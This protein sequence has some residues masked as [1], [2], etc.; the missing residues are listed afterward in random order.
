[1]KT[2]D[3]GAVAIATASRFNALRL[4][5][6]VALICGLTVGGFHP[7][8]AAAGT[9]KATAKAATSGTILDAG[10]PD[11]IP[12]RYIVVLQPSA[13]SGTATVTS[14][15]QSLTSTYG[16]TVSLVEDGF[17]AFTLNGTDAIASAMAGDSQVSYVDQ[18]QTEE[19]AAAPAPPPVQDNPDWGLARINQRMPDLGS[20]PQFAAA[21]SAGA[22]IYVVDTGVQISAPDFGGRAS[23]AYDAMTKKDGAGP[24]CSIKIGH[25]TPV[26]ALAAGSVYG[27]AKQALIKS[28]KVMDCD[29]NGKPVDADA[30]VTNDGLDWILE[31]ATAPAVVNL[32]L[33]KDKNVARAD[34][35]NRLVYKGFIVVMAAGNKATDA[36]NATPGSKT[37]DGVPMNA[38]VVGATSLNKTTTP[39]V[40]KLHALSNFGNCVT[41]FAPGGNVISAAA[42][43]TT[44]APQAICQGTSFAAGY[45]SGAA[46]IL[47]AANPKL[48]QNQVK[49]ALVADATSPATNGVSTLIAGAAA[50]NS[51]DLL[52]HVAPPAPQ[53]TVTVNGPAVSQ[54][55][56]SGPGAVDF[57]FS[58][59]AGQSVYVN[60]TGG[61]FNANIALYDKMGSQLAGGSH[62]SGSSG[63]QES[64]INPVVLPL[65]GTYSIHVVPAAGASGT[66]AL[67]VLTAAAVTATVNGPAVTA[68]IPSS[69]PGQRIL[70]TF[71]G[72]AGA[73]VY[74]NGTTGKYRS[75]VTLY[76]PSGAQIASGNGS[77]SGSPSSWI[78]STPLSKTGTYTL[79]I[80]PDPGATGAVTFQVF[81]SDVTLT[82]TVDGAAVTG[83]IP[84]SLPGQH[85]TAKFTG[86]AG[87]SITIN[88]TTPSFH[89]S[90]TLFDPTG[91]QIASTNY[92]G[93][94]SGSPWSWFSS[95]PLSK[96]GTYTLSI[97]PDPGATGAVTLHVIGSDLTLT[98]TVDG[99]AVSG[100]IPASLP[101]QHVT[102]R[103]AGTAGQSVDINGA[104]N[105]YLSAL[106]LYDPTGAQIGS[107]NYSGSSSGS[108]SSWFSSV[109]L[110]TTGTYTLSLVPDAGA[111]GPVKVQVLGSAI[112]LTPTVDGAAVSGT[113]PAA[114][115]GKRI[116][117]TFSATAGQAIYINGSTTGFTPWMKLY[118]P[119]GVQIASGNGVTSFPGTPQTWIRPTNAPTTGTYTLVINPDAT[120]TGDFSLQ[121]FGSYVTGG[122][123]VNGAP[124]ALL[125]PPS[126]PGKIMAITFSGTAGSVVG[127]EGITGTVGGVLAMDDPDGAQIASGVAIPLNQCPEDEAPGTCPQV[128]IVPVTLPLTGT[129]TVY[130]TT[131]P[132]LWGPLSVELTGAPGV[133]PPVNLISAPATV[134][135]APATVSIPSAS[136]ANRVAVT[137]SATAGQAITVNS[138]RG[139]MDCS[140]Q[141]FSLVGPSGQIV[142]PQ[143]GV[144][145]CS[146]P[147]FLFLT[148]LPADGTYT[149]Y[150]FPSSSQTG[151]FTLQV[152]SSYVTASAT[153]DGPS[154]PI[155]IPSTSPGRHAALTFAGTAGQAVYVNFARETS[156]CDSQT[157]SLVGPSGQIIVPQTGISPCS[158]LV[159]L[160]PTVLPAT[161]T[162]TLYEF[163]SSTQSGT[164]GLQV[165]SKYLTATA[166]VDGPTTTVTIPSS[167]PGQRAAITF[168]GTAGQAIYVNSPKGTVD[169]SLMWFSLVGPS[170]QVV[171][172]QTGTRLCGN[173]TVASPTALP[174]TGTYTLYVTPDGDG[175]FGLQVLSQSV[176]ALATV[177][178]P[179]IPITVPSSSPGEHV[180]VTFSAGAG[181]VVYVNSASGTIDCSYMAFSLIG[182]SGQL[183]VPQAGTR[184]CSAETVISPIALPATGTY[185]LYLFPVA[186]QTGTFG[187]QVLTKY[188]AAAA[189]V[190]G[191]AVPITI[192]GNAP[193]QR[194]AETFSATAGQA[195]S[196]SEVS[197]TISCSQGA[198]WISL[199]GPS[200]QVVV[201][202]AG[203]SDLCG[204]GVILGKTGLP[205]TGTYTL[206][207]SPATDQS[208]TFS[209]QT[210]SYI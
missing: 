103:F 200:G 187:L 1:M 209:L 210:Q 174:A 120:A 204:T 77:S 115:P 181:Q 191:A 44:L 176:T 161:G 45:V 49:A 85:V 202:Q 89:S 113:I 50:E 145:L 193:G 189:T 23:Y 22:T 147:T 46:A 64:W 51:P 6:F 167:S 17:Q 194:V 177:D 178:G 78:S 63:Q 104:T 138:T 55:V 171:T 67:Q 175:T 151:T 179:A 60:G 80:V 128:L 83:T 154:V 84:A 42:N 56:G 164:F 30:A 137:F 146:S 185:T 190:D 134:D 180:A 156:G 72:T 62:S 91:A 37:K 157:F 160:P 5:L 58:G 27:V 9:V 53:N 166:T 29:A 79:S 117:A 71:A 75:S 188:V 14:V 109:R 70:A 111:T 7:P 124:T 129:Y 199:V 116:T 195:V 61:A 48:T 81:G 127:M 10:S 98:P 2:S 57:T 99:A 35:V 95:T 173:S 118:D 126:A 76:D 133:A 143:T 41:L 141:T 28:V 4:V 182:P 130:F 197:S 106:T 152:L 26:A 87:Q 102:V 36:C 92:Y 135:G 207:I 122:A 155:A 47:L 38:I 125:V 19:A 132:G 205:A 31:N 208:G 94:S 163:P 184:L 121:V 20:D 82:P 110:G 54:T 24:D 73:S 65:T 86:T 18:D 100:T 101:G 196:I 39:M 131:D 13:V 43:P 25:G 40:D 119:A 201:S 136:A 68:T 139:T 32:S 192:S 198:R 96:T 150:L 108:A 15:A 52:L 105:S 206:Y 169:C 140:S 158:S 34:I 11:A 21:S 69:L 66:V 162:Y 112:A 186:G 16:G 172:Q 148:G 149:L 159:V 59:T 123:T 144:S 168:A 74:V 170:G 3:S 33:G 114:T 97:V 142:V 165:L 93:S 90:V 8:S 183:V 12:G 88:G 203:I 107:T 153:I